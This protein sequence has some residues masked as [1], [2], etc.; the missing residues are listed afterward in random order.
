MIKKRTAKEAVKRAIAEVGY[1][2]NPRGSNSTKYG[3]IYGMDPAY[4]CAM[5]IWWVINVGS[6]N[7]IPKTAYT[8][9]LE[10]WAR[11]KGI[12]RGGRSAAKA[13]DLVLFQMPGPDRVNHVGIVIRDRKEGAP[14]YTVEGNTGG[15]NPRAG[16]MVAA[17]KRVQHIRYI[18][19]MSKVYGTEQTKPKPAIVYTLTRTLSKGMKGEAVKMLQRKLRLPVDGNF[20]DAVE[21]AVVKY[22]KRQKLDADGVVGKATAK[23]LGWKFTGK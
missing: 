9:A 19:D 8:P 13:G 7:I 12:L 10:S 5:F 15:T 23:R 3:K 18:I 16:G 6:I 14:V 21:D 11:K 2:E 22:Q 20:T 1:V 17:N 4:W